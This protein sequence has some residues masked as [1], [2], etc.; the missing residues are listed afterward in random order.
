[1]RVFYQKIFF[2][3]SKTIFVSF[4]LLIALN[5][6][7]FERAPEDTFSSPINVSK[8]SFL[9]FFKPQVLK[10]NVFKGKRTIFCWERIWISKLIFEGLINY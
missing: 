5:F 6:F 4:N 2:K 8:H 7:Q 1:M 9:F 10:M 3:Y